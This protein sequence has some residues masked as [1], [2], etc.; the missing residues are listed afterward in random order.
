MSRLESKSE[1]NGTVSKMEDM[2]R[3]RGGAFLCKGIDRF[4]RSR[5]FFLFHATGLSV[6]G[7]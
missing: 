7:A 5:A 3:R 4:L 1:G 6:N 2:A